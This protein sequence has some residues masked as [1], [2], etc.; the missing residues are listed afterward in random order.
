MLPLLEVSIV[1]TLMLLIIT[2]RK[3]RKIVKLHKDDVSS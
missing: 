2:N 3:V 1:S